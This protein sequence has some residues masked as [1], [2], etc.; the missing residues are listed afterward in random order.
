MKPGSRILVAGHRGLVDSAIVRALRRDGLTFI[1][2]PAR[3]QLDLENRRQVDEFFRNERPEFVFLAAAKVGGIL[4]NSSYPPDFIRANLGI[5]LDAIDAAYREG[6]TNLLS[7]GSSCIC[8]KNSPQPIKEE[9]LITGS[10]EPT[11]RLCHCQDRQPRNVPLVHHAVRHG[12]HLGRFRRICMALAT[13]S[14]YRLVTY[15]PRRS[16]NSTSRE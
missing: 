3:D 1:L 15:S 5:E 11:K 10:L 4:A 6:V 7:P 14:I 12:V 16:G 8:P 2:P 13:I 9:Y